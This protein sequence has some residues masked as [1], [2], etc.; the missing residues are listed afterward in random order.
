M[1][2]EWYR[3]NQDLKNACAYLSKIL[4]F[5]LPIAQTWG[6]LIEKLWG[7]LQM[8]ARPPIVNSSS[9][10]HDLLVLPFLERQHTVSILGELS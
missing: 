8:I 4:A 6:V 3:P 5:V 10:K 7:T 9:P 1:P 2:L